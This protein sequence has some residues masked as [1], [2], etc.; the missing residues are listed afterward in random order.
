MI[1]II[2]ANNETGV[3]QPVEEIGSVARENHILFHTDAV[4]AVGKIPV[5]VDRTGADLMSISAHKIYGPKGV[6]ALYVKKETPVQPILTG[7]HHEHNLR[8]GTE[9]I[10]GIVGFAEA[11]N[12]AAGSLAEEPSR[13]AFLRDRLET[14]I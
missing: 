4:Q 10:A 7:G 3:I 5:H 9:N 8:A 12:L 2:Y 14:I 11:L 1:S 6:G 13:L